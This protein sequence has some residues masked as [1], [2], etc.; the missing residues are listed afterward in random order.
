MSL[1]LFTETK[2]IVSLDSTFVCAELSAL[3]FTVIDRS[4][5]P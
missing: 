5:L 1:R 2:L 4:V 3:P